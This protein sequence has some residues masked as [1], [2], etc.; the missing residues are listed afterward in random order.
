MTIEEFYM[1]NYNITL[2]GEIFHKENGKKLRPRVA[3]RGYLTVS[4]YNCNIYKTFYVHRLMA[5]TFLPQIEGKTIVN[6]KDGDKTNNKI[7]NLEWMTHRENSLHSV[8]TLKKEVGENHSRCRLPNEV[9]LG[10]INNQ[11]CED[12]FLEIS[13]RYGVGVQHLKNIKAGRKRNSIHFLT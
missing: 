3:T 5:L 1:E 8:K 7:T 9:V 2:C 10:I 4:L 12:K 11:I 13:Q 6:H